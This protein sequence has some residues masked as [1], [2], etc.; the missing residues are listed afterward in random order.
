MAPIAGSSQVRN[1]L[2]DDKENVPMSDEDLDFIMDIPEGP[3]MQENGYLS[4]TSSFSRL[5]APELLSP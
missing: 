2:G 5:D 3:V 1:F 4:R